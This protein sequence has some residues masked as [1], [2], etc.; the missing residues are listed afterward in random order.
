MTLSSA[1][2][3]Y[4]ERGWPVHPLRFDAAPWAGRGVKA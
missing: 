4:A 3:A 2:I 1:A